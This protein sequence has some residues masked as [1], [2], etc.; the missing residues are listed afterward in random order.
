MYLIIMQIAN[1]R[2]AADITVKEVVVLGFLYENII[3]QILTP[4][5]QLRRAQ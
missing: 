1:H 2:K 4:N 5:V 3:T